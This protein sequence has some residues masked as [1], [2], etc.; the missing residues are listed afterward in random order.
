M[1]W[2]S[3][4]GWRHAVGVG[5]LL[6]SLFPIV[7]VLSAALNPL[8]TL[9]STSVVPTGFTAGNFVKLWRDTPFPNWD[10]KSILI[11][12]S[13]AAAAGVLSIPPAD[14]FGRRGFARGR[15]GV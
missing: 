14:A 1:T 9:S 3:R 2:L 13:S 12:G 15:G 10:L 11:A 4:V 5:A 7:F 6:F 8:G